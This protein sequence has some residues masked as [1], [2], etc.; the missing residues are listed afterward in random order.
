MPSPSTF[1]PP[2]SPVAR[3]LAGALTTETADAEDVE[4]VALMYGRRA[5][6]VRLLYQMCMARVWEAH[7]LTAETWLAPSN[8][9]VAA[10]GVTL[11]HASEDSRVGVWDQL[12]AASDAVEPL[13][14]GAQAE[15]AAALAAEAATYPIVV[16]MVAESEAAPS[17]MA[18]K[19]VLPVPSQ[20]RLLRQRL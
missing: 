16:L 20:Q 11:L 7:G 18:C 4:D 9:P 15:V 1:A 5:P 8:D 2:A 6:A 17:Y 19:I 3:L 14:S 12:A 10:C 13:A